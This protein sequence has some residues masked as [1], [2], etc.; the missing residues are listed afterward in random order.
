[1]VEKVWRS[2][3][4]HIM[5][6]RKQRKQGIL[7]FFKFNLNFFFLILKEITHKKIGY[8]NSDCIFDDVKELL[9][10]F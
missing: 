8:L 10:I 6:A 1:M 5:V 4:I 2:T 9:L 3:E 7:I